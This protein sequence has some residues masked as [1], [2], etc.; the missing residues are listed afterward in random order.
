VILCDPPFFNVSLSRLFTALRTLARNDF[1]QPLLV[2]YLVRRARNVIGT[3]AP[4][5][6]APTGLHPEYVTVVNCDRND[7][8]FFSNLPEEKVPRWS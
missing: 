6:L 8:E 1:S 3:F 5:G 2:S 4:F 7:I